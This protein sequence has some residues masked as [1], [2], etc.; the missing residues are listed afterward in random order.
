VNT[1]KN[2]QNVIRLLLATALRDS[3]RSAP[4]INPRRKPCYRYAGTGRAGECGGGLE[5]ANRMFATGSR[6]PLSPEWMLPGI[7]QM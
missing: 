2:L 1:T 7:Y 5:G 4:V 3:K 6:I